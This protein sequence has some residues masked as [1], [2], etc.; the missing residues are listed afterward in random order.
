MMRTYFV[1][2]LSGLVIFFAVSS[3]ALAGILPQDGEARYELE[4]WE[5]I[6]DSTD[7]SDYEAYLE[8]Y[9][10]GRFAPL[11]RARAAR[12]K[13]TAAPAAP[14]PAPKP[15]PVKVD[16]M[17]VWYEVVSN[18]NLRK[19]PSS[20]GTR[21]GEL[22]R[23]STVHVTGKVAGQNWFR[24]AI[25]GGATGY[26]YGDLVRKPAPKPTPKPK[27]KPAPAKV[28]APKV[29]EYKLETVRDCP[30]CPEMVVLPAG[31]FTM[32]DSR[33]D[34]S[35]K[36]A[37]KVSIRRPFAIG[38]YEVTVG[39]WAECV[40]AG[41]CSHKSDKM[42]TDENSPARDI[43]WTDANEYVQWLS[44]TTGKN[45]RL[46]TEAEWEYAARAGTTTRFW[47]GDRLVPGKASCKDCGGK[48]DR[49][50]P[51]SVDTFPANPFG[52]HGMN[53]S[54]WEW[55]SDC[56]H[57]NYNGAPKDGRSW[58]TADCRQQVIRGGSWRNDSSYIHSASRFKYDSNVRYLLNG[59]RVAR[60]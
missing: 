11:A 5:S 57:K 53:G 3:T 23:G 12:Y 54:V 43:S 34:R 46:P 16:E 15:A 25:P 41:A 40:R 37:H 1:A 47:W 19:S 55:V 26:V 4:F 21:L 59:F 44:T 30:A 2:G 58:D 42:G 36:P 35:E 6:K 49:K 50:A 10:N 28:T 60:D 38:K 9:P 20:K 33:G 7:A 22:K 24:V 48:W 17:D 52:L 29:E 56:W 31:T 32:G 14:P 45:Y 8:A 51:A 18:A 13:K 27:P 39:Q